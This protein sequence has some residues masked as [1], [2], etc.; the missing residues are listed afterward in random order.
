MGKLKEAYKSLR[1]KVSGRPT[2]SA[3]KAGYTSDGN[4]Y[5]CGGKIKR[6]KS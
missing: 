3:P 1:D 4:R 6:K 2:P 5:G